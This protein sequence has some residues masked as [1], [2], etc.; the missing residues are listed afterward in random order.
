MLLARKSRSFGV[1][2]TMALMAVLTMVAVWSSPAAATGF[3]RHQMF[4][5]GSA[6]AGASDGCCEE[7]PERRKLT[8]RSG[9]GKE[10]WYG[11]SGHTDGGGES[12]TLAD[13][14]DEVEGFESK[15]GD[16]YFSNFTAETFGLAPG[17]LERY[18]VIP[19]DAGFKILTHL[20]ALFGMSSELD[21][22]YDV[23]A[24]ATD[25]RIESASVNFVGMALGPG[26]STGVE[27][28]MGDAGQLAAEV[29]RGAGRHRFGGLQGPV[30]DHILFGQAVSDLAVSE[31][32]GAVS[33]CRHCFFA[34]GF[35]KAIMVQHS[36]G[37]TEAVPEPGTFAL[38]AM[39][40]V[41]LGVLGR[42]R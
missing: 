29:T 1:R 14:V 13:L 25:Y 11:W 20:R 23:R 12:L 6:G 33:D 39:G 40:V 41:G 7:A 30:S 32:V 42:W 18:K 38:M 26:A 2:E 31:V 9:G 28:D 4:D 35:S 36:F 24:M 5:W 10:H 21:F 27:M 22:E 37:T 3:G 15:N 17:N 34:G 19:T 16:L 8:P